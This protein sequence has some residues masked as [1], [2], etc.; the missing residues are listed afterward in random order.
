MDKER[1]LSFFDRRT[2]IFFAAL[3]GIFC[4]VV[5]AGMIVS[6]TSYRPVA[7]FEEEEFLAMK[8]RLKQDPENEELRQA[9]RAEDRTRIEGYFESR[10]KMQM[11]GYLL[12]GGVF[13][14]ALS[15]RRLTVLNRQDPEPVDSSNVRPESADRSRAI[16]SALAIPLPLA[17][18]ALIALGIYHAVQEKAAEDGLTVGVVGAP[19]TV[20]VPDNRKWAQFRGTIGMGR[21]PA[22]DLPLSWNAETGE[23]ILWKTRVPSKGNSSPIV[24]GD[25]LFLTGGDKNARRVL[26]YDTGA[27]NLLWSA[28]IRTEA[29]MDEDLDNLGETGYA[30]PTAVTDGTSVFA[31]FGTTELVALDFFGRQIWSRWFGKPDSMYGIS[32]SPIFHGG[33]LFLQLDQGDGE[34]GKSFLYSIDPRT[35]ETRWKAP[36]A[37][38]GSWTSPVVVDTGTREELI[39]AADP[40]VIAYVPADGSELWRANVLSG[41][42]APVPAYSDGTVFTVT[43]YAQLA[44]TRVGGSGDVTETHVRWT[45]DD[46]LPDVAS[47]VTDGR[48]I[49]VPTG[50]GTVS[51]LNTETGEEIWIHDF[52]E[53]FWSSPILVGKTVYMTDK[54]G[55]THIFD[56]ADTYKERGAG[57]VGEQVFTTPAFADSR[58]F[59]RGQTHLYCVGETPQ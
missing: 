10:R 12:F 8:E 54:M 2:T 22:M 21:I 59:I 31:F 57:S 39:T 37:L 55:D 3:S 6:A 32:T 27:G 33:S 51:C 53:G 9:I 44:A 49:L 16:L 7:Y 18:A 52:D 11:G 29:V 42:V 1:V 15:M 38:P 36:R 13:V 50:Y 41:D 26:C 23:N 28:P 43:E 19:D 30:S 48:R 34:D 25:R 24:W 58:I 14:F 40:W 46:Y 17:V 56:L 35:G 4:T 47:P 5:I 45:W 20:P